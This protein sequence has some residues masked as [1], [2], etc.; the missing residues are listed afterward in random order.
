MHNVVI[1][2]E[3]MDGS[4]SLETAIPKKRGRPKKINLPASP[5]SPAF[6]DM[7]EDDDLPLAVP[8]SK[9]FVEK[10]DVEDSLVGKI[11][12]IRRS[13]RPRKA[14]LP[15][16]PS[17]PLHIEKEEESVLTKR[18]ILSSKKHKEITGIEDSLEENV[19]PKKR[20]RPKKADLPPTPS[21]PSCS[22]NGREGNLPAVRSAR[23][24]EPRK[25]FLVPLLE[26]TEENFSESLASSK[27]GRKRKAMSPEDEM[28]P[29]SPVKIKTIPNVV[30]GVCKKEMP[31]PNFTYHR[32]SVHYGLAR[33][34]GASQVFTEVE[35]AQQL[36][37]TLEKI[38]RLSCSKCSTSFTTLLGFQYHQKRCGVDAADL[39]NML[40]EC[41]ICGKRV[42]A[43]TAHMKVHEKKPENAERIKAAT[44]VPAPSPGTKSR[45]VAAQ[46]AASL[47]RELKEDLVDGSTQKPLSKAMKLFTE[48]ASSKVTNSII[49]AWK[50]QIEQNSVAQCRYPSCPFSSDNI[51][52]LKEHHVQCEIGSRSKCF[53]CLKCDFRSQDRSQ[54]LEHALNTHVTEKDDAFELSGGSSSSSSEDT[55]DDSDAE[56]G[57]GRDSDAEDQRLNKKKSVPQNTKNVEK[58]YGLH[59]HE[60]QQFKSLS[61]SQHIPVWLAKFHK[62]NFTWETSL[63]EAWTPNVKTCVN[64]SSHYFPSNEQSVPFARRL[65]T[66]GNLFPT[67][68]DVT[69]ERLL[70]FQSKLQNG[71]PTFFCGGS[72]QSASWC[73]MPA[74]LDGAAVDRDQY[75]ALS[76]FHEE[77]RFRS[78]SQAAFA[79]ENL[80]QIWNCGTLHN[81]VPPQVAP[82]LEICVA[83]NYGRI[84]SLV[85]CPS[86]C[87]DKE[88]LGLLAAACS[89]GT[90][91]IFSIPNTS[92]STKNINEPSFLRIC[93]N[94]TLRLNTT[95]TSECTSL[96]W[97]STSGHKF[98]IAGFANGI[99]ALW[100]LQTKSPLLLRKDGHYPV[101]SFYA[102]SSVVTAVSLSPHH[103]DARFIATASTDRT[104]KLWDRQDLAVPI[105]WSKRSR[106]TDIKWRRHWPGVLVCVEDVCALF[107]SSSMFY[108]FGYTGNKQ[109]LLPQNSV[110]WSSAENEYLDVIAHCTSAGEIV[111][112]ASHLAVFDCDEKKL[113]K[114]R[115]LILRTD[116]I[117]ASA[118]KDI[119]LN[120]M[121]KSYLESSKK[122]PEV[123][124]ETRENPNYSLVFNDVT[125]SG[126][127]TIGNRKQPPVISVSAENMDV[128]M[129]CDDPLTSI[130]KISFNPN[131]ES[132]TWMCVCGESG[133]VQLLKINSPSISKV[134]DCYVKE[135]N[136]SYVNS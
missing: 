35:K 39:Q 126:I 25:K 103:S 44:V 41:T 5:T 19:T 130:N 27:R 82:H 56:G 118:R 22:D 7:R 119:F 26:P 17:S 93:A 48:P 134:T 112:Y 94:V 104:V 64:L 54:I 28:T 117:D 108:D 92:L 131:L 128:H 63:Y 50:K 21:S 109:A 88:R 60:L 100:D 45:R 6:S 69:L 23:Q 75:L 96:D 36:K 14:T 110:V 99:V 66:S 72:I 52:I 10:I 124:T 91:R 53:A 76:I 61:T 133:L 30:C 46:K 85:W 74:V 107:R 79:S 87:Y 58:A 20:G 65:V 80:I 113:R 120:R 1:E 15:A 62:R 135:M 11:T 98:I 123:K 116:L 8:S 31:Q 129:P 49:G 13:G 86:G 105:S 16:T 38:K 97:D 84:W 3:N 4:A 127:R 95:E 125:S 43:L 32:Y 18:K 70:R 57:I 33:L 121:Q 122:A 68:I 77:H 37:K 106:V 102:H 9:G 67:K 81:T 73:P 115:I 101:W 24:S 40:N 111:I 12:P 78:A 29:K 55:E 2:K 59:S 83:H 132:H 136:S 51:E 42:M 71:T 89:D 114:Q 47:L 34:E 90:I